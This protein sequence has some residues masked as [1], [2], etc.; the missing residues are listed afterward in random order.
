M[1]AITHAPRILCITLRN[2]SVGHAVLD[3]FGIA[4]GSFFTTRLDHLRPSRRY[5]RLVRLLRASC[6][7]FHPTRIVFGLPGARHAERL[8]LAERLAR[9]LRSL[10]VAFTMKRLADAA[11]LLVER[12]RYTMAD[13]VVERLA[14]HFVPDLSPL[15]ARTQTSPRYWRAAWYAVAI[16]LATLV[17]HHPYDAA[18]LAQPSAFLLRPFREALRSALTPA[19]SYAS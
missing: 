5:Q 11:R 4:E 9:R 14:E 18:A 1:S 3:G 17:E 13:E 12:L 6:R 10:N 19:A 7:R 15:V 2:G 16:A 8:A